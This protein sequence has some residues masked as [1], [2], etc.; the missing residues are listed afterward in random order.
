MIVCITQPTYLSWIGYLAMIDYCDMFVVYDDVQFSHQSWQ[1]RNRIKSN[2]K[3][4]WLT[5]PIERN[6]GQ[7][8]NEVKINGEH[9]AKDHWKTIEQNYCKAPYFKK[10]QYNF[11]L[12]YQSKWNRL[13]DLN[14]KLLYTLSESIKINIPP[15]VFSSTIKTEGHKTDRLLPILKELKADTYISGV[16]AK[17]YL[18][19]EKLKQNGIITKWF[20]YKH[21][22]YPQ[23]GDD[24]IPYMTALDLLF[25][26][27]D[28]AIDYLRQGVKL[29]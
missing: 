10:Y 7:L 22:I 12:I 16:A 13:V 26:T 1:H 3:S 23:L 11:E 2:D 29:G 19:V 28:K 24:F 9:W 8:I 15:I 14:V 17:N 4:I 5:V 6:E 27:G 18:D 20:E 25:N 21:P